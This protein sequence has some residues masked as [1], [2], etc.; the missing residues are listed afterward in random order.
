MEAISFKPIFD[1][2]SRILIL[3]TMPGIKSLEKQQYYGH[4]RNA[5]WPVIFNLLNSEISTNYE[6][7]IKLLIDNKIALWDTLQFCTRQGSLDSNIQDE[8][9]ND[10]N[11]FISKI[12]DLKAIFFN[13][14]SAEKY[15]KKY[16]SRIENILYF[17]MPSTSQANARM[18]THEKLAKWSVLK[19]LINT[20]QP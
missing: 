6:N 18:R 14:Q 1:Q 2:N 17:T 3:G 19:D 20:E 13:G 7:K 15:Y 10:I 11:G 9:P 4:E 16:H 12:K 5:F 8:K